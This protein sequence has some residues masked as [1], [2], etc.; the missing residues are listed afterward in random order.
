MK[1][2]MKRKIQKVIRNF[3]ISDMSKDEKYLKF[4]MNRH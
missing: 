1:R 4:I 3:G 2:K